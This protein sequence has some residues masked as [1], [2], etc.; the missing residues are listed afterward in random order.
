MSMNITLLG[1]ALAGGVFSAFASLP[2]EDARQKALQAVFDDLEKG[3]KAKDEALFKARWHADGYEKNLCGG[4]GLAGK[5]VFGQGSRK[6][7]F[8]KPDL[9]K[10]RIVEGGAVV[11][12]FCEVFA[13][14]K[15]KAV[16]KVDMI[17]VK[18]KESYLVL[19]GGEKRDDVDGLVSRWLKKEPLEAPKKP[20]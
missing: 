2:Q 11:V 5:G 14:E 8:L 9:A 4:S 18:D 20:E 10:A 3:I 7:W 12:V 1:I 19:G 16:D 13:W 15:E 6:K 17:L